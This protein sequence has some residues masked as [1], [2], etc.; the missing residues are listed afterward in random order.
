MADYS[1]QGINE[2]PELTKDQWVTYFFSL[3]SVF[4]CRDNLS[5]QRRG[6]HCRN[7]LEMCQSRHH[8]MF[9]GAS[10]QLEQQSMQSACISSDMAFS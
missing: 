7:C 3:V 5:K 10:R 9:N 4:D 8:E 6:M 2:D 1:K